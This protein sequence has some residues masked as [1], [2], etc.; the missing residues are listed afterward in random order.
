ML[1]LFAVVLL[2]SAFSV[3]AA[4]TALTRKL[5]PGMGLLA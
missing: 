2:V 4:L 3:S 5:A 1:V